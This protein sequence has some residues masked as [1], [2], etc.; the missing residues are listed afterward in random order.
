MN[1][2][3]LN[4][5]EAPPLSDEHLTILRDSGMPESMAQY[6]ARYAWHKFPAAFKE[7]AEPD[8]TDTYLVD[9]VTNVRWPN[10]RI[11]YPDDRADCW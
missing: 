7:W 6:V 9:L 2:I 3:D 4:D 8:L 5:V 1:D 10:I 11:K